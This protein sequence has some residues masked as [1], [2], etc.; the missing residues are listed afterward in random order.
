M[1]NKIFYLLLFLI[2]LYTFGIINALNLPLLGKV[3]YI[4]PGHGGTDPGAIYNDLYESNLNLQIS[5]KIQTELEKNGAIVYLTRYGDY[6][7]SVKNAINRKRSDLSRRAN[8]INDS[9]ADVYLSI[10]LNSDV[11]STWQGSQAFYDTVNDKNEILAKI[12]QEQFKIDLNTNREYKQINDHYLYQ[13]VKVP[14]VL[15]EVGFISNA[16]ERYLLK[17]DSYQEKIAISIKNG[18]IKYFTQI[19]RI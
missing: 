12:M 3:I 4:D 15:L 14:G 13:R 5:L 2:S 9:N 10:H 7:L 19:K 6:D 18:L 11:S 16:N 1:K 17:Q 8:I